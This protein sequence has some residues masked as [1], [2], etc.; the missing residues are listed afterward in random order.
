MYSV[1]LSYDNYTW[2][3]LPEL[4]YVIS[5]FFKFSQFLNFNLQTSIGCLNTYISE[6]LHI[7]NETGARCKNTMK[8]FTV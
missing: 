2:F 3:D 6:D 8:F 5:S 4:L 1:F 7:K